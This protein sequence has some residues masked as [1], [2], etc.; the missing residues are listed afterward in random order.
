MA[1]PTWPDINGGSLFN[2][3]YDQLAE[4]F[5]WG[6]VIAGLLMTFIGWQSSIPT[7]WS[8]HEGPSAAAFGL[9]VLWLV[10][11]LPER[12]SN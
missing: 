7:W 8:Y 2:I 1:Y 6:S 9:L 3:F 11:A 5:G 10:R 4:A 12:E